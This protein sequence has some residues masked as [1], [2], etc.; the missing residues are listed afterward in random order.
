MKT[1]ESLSTEDTVSDEDAAAYLEKHSITIDFGKD[2][3]ELKRTLKPIASFSQVLPRIPSGLHSAFASFKEPTPIQSC[4]WPPLLAGRD[5]VGIAETGR[6]VASVLQAYTFNHYYIAGKHS[7]SVYLQSQNLYN[8]EE[9]KKTRSSTRS[10][11]E[12]RR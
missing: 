7:R 12:T 10:R 5:V 1:E 4:T 6:F 9:A 8:Q 2:S 3:G 11:R